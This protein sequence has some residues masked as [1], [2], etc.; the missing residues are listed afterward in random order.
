MFGP[1]G[2]LKKAFSS[3]PQRPSNA[4]QG[5]ACSAAARSLGT[6]KDDRAHKRRGELVSDPE[7]SVR[8]AAGGN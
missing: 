8:A 2:P 4:I 1:V 3:S 5:K 6:L 7:L